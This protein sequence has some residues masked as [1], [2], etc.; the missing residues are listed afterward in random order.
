MLRRRRCRA[1]SDGRA[2][3][4]QPGALLLEMESVALGRRAVVSVAARPPLVSPAISSVS[5]SVR[6]DSRQVGTEDVRAVCDPAGRLGP[7]PTEI[8]ALGA[9]A[10]A[11]VLYVEVTRPA[12]PGARGPAGGSREPL[13]ERGRGAR[14]AVQTWAPGSLPVQ[15]R[16]RWIPQVTTLATWAWVP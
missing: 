12:L 8:R 11:F 1:R 4:P 16:G 5:S 7:W 10:S 2:A 3:A 15:P 6:L 14:A 13:P 9:P